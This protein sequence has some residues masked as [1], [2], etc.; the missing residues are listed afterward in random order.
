MATN[1]PTN[2]GNGNTGGDGVPNLLT[3]VL[4]LVTGTV[5]SMG[6]SNVTLPPPA[7][8]TMIQSIVSSGLPGVPINHGEKL[9][10][11]KG[12]DF[13]RWQQKML[14][15][16]TMFN[17]AKVLDEDAPTVEKDE[18]DKQK[19]IAVEAWKHTD[20]LCRNYV[21]N[22]LDDTLYNVYAT[23]KTAKEL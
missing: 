8:V 6:T 1:I 11:F 15:Y 5:L 17:L 7:V 13:K 21:L 2:D 14:F 22:G 10:K 9:E 19:L 23:K 3:G 16:L 4:N 12:L 20:F 18:T